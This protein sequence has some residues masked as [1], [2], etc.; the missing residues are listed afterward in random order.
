M[1][2]PINWPR[3]PPMPVWPLPPYPTSRPTRSDR[4]WSSNLDRVLSMRFERGELAR[5]CSFLC[6]KEIHKC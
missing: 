4:A 2:W 6:F 1:N 5:N 3:P